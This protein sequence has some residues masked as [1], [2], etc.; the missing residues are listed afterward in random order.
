MSQRLTDRQ[1]EYLDYIRNYIQRNES[2]PRLDEIATHFGI[3]S[4]TTHKALDTLQEKGYLYFGRDSVSGFYIQLIEFVDIS[5]EV[6]EISILGN[7]DQFGIVHKFP[8]KV[9]H[10]V[11][12]TLQSNPKDLFA[13][14]ISANLP[15]FNLVPHDIIIMDQ[16]REPQVG[17]ICMTLVNDDRILIQITDED[18][19]TG[20]LSW[21]TLD[22]NDSDN[23]VTSEKQKSLAPYPQLLPRDFI[24]ATALRLTRYLAY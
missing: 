21:M 3:T 6:A 20:R 22:A 10:T 11:T 2:A 7:V 8:Q 14:R 19:E 5:V 12:L 13:L 15:E 16:G 18:Q 23:P 9:S 1:Q 24:L 17:D 4:P